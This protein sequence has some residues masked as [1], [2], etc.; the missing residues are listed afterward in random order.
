M[1]LLDKRRSIVA[2]E[3]AQIYP[4]PLYLLLAI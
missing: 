2:I 3:M 1:T 4:Y